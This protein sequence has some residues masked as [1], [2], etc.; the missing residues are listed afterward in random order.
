MEH[1]MK[2]KAPEH[3]TGIHTGGTEYRADE[4]GI[5]ELPADAPA[6]HVE[7][8]LAHGWTRV[9]GKKAAKPRKASSKPKKS[10][11][12]AKANAAPPSAAE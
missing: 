2:F 9:G 8:L 7:A 11:P 3:V 4:N 6:A 10:A 5:A 12:K 1:V